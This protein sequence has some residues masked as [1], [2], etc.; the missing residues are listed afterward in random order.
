VTLPLVLPVAPDAVAPAARRDGVRRRLLA[1]PT[2][3][4]ALGVL[5]AL[6]LV[7]VVAPLVWPYAPHEQLDLATM[8]LARPSVAHPLGTDAVARDVLARLLAGGRLSL[9]IGLASV[10]LSTCLGT[11]W[12]MAAG[13][14]GP[15]TDALLMRVVDAGLAVPR[16][17]VLLVVL[18]LRETPS[19]PLLVGAIAAT[20]WF[21]LARLVRGEVRRLRRSDWIVAARALGVPST[22]IALRHLLPH[23]A[24]PVLVTAAL[25]VGHVIVLEAGLSWLGIGVQPPGASWGNIIRDG[26]DVLQGAPWISLAPGA[27][28]VVVV[29][30]CS[31]LADGLR[32]ALAG[33]DLPRP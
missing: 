16:V 10:T 12:G 2:V 27:C 5:G 1:T 25:G 4:A 17:L 26:T 14:G 33:R 15:R 3:R 8:S 28:L 32:D 18:A 13:L 31:L 6:A 29:L 30:C 9:A 23:V 24:G 22:R 7:L 20:G 11:A 19:V 21:T